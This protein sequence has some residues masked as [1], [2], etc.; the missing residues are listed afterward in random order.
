VVVGRDGYM[1]VMRTDDTED[2]FVDTLAYVVKG[3][4][5]VS[6][7]MLIEDEEEVSIVDELSAAKS[8]T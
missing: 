3:P 4:V 1:V 8:A 7:S 5:V 6:T 2:I